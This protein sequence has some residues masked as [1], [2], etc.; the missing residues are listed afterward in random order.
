ML[1]F[2]SF[3]SADPLTDS[4]PCLSCADLTCGRGRARG[5]GVAPLLPRDA[6]QNF[7]KKA[8]VDAK[9]AM[10]EEKSDAESSSHDVHLNN[11]C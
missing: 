2:V 9:T 4:A 10:S 11:T 1:V 5:E 6:R 3:S 7:T 8:P